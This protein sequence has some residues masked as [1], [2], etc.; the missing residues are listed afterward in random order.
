MGLLSWF[1][2]KEHLFFGRKKHSISQN[3]H[4]TSLLPQVPDMHGR[5]N[6][7]AGKALIGIK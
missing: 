2:G 3:P 6:I 4:G 5:T 7:Y 1:H